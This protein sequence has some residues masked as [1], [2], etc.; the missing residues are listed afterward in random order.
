M[1]MGAWKNPEIKRDISELFDFFGA[2]G[3]FGMIK[4]K[5][6]SALIGCDK[7][8]IIMSLIS[9]AEITINKDSISI[10]FEKD[11]GVHYMRFREF[12]SDNK[13]I[14]ALKKTFYEFGVCP[15]KIE[16]SVILK[17]D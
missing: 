12:F 3:G 10:V 8:D 17:G 15:D 5:I 4:S 6:R 16:I 9:P 11:Y 14:G 1:P 7:A 2:V 13:V